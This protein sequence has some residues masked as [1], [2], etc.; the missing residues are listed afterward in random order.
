MHIHSSLAPPGATLLDRVPEAKLRVWAKD[1]R[2][3]NGKQYL[4]LL[5][6]SKL[7]SLIEGKKK[8][9]LEVF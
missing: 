8:E 1:G 5:P 4:P 7:K 3:D 6:L 9:Q 2:A